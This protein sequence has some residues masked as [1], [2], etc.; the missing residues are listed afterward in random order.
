MQPYQLAITALVSFLITVSMPLNFESVAILSPSLTAV[1]TQAESRKAEAEQLFQQGFEQYQQGQ[2]ETA[3]EFWQQALKIYQELQIREKEGAV[4]GNLGIAYKILGEYAVAIDFHQQALAI[5]QQ[6][7]DRQGEGQVLGN[8]GNAYEAV[9]EYEKAIASYQQSFAIAQKLKDLPGEAI[10]LGNLGAI[11]ATLDDNDQA[12]KYYEQSLLIAQEIK[13][14]EIA[15]FLLNNL[16]TLYYTQNNVSKALATYQQSLEFAQAVGNQQ[17]ESE[18]LINLGTASE[19][20]GNHAQAIEHYNEVLKIAQENGDRRLEK[21]AFN[22]LG[23]ALFNSGN[24]VEAES[25]LREAIKIL[26]SLRPGLND[27]E[28]VSIFDTQILS[29][30][31]LQ[32]I[33]IAQDKFEA[34]LEVSE[35]GR[36]RAFVEL[37]AKRLSSEV[38]EQSRLNSDSPSIAKIKQIAQEHNATIVEYSLVPDEDF[39]VQGKQRGE[40]SE[41]LIWV[42]Q[43]T[44]KIAFRRV[45]L[46]TMRQQNETTL[47]SLVASSR[48]SMGVIGRGFVNLV[49]KP[50]NQQTEE[51]SLT[52]SLQKLHQLLIEPIT[53]FLPTDPNAR[54][55]F[56]PQESLFLVPF[57]ALQDA[58]GKYLIEK[59]TILTAPAIQ[60]LDLTYEQSQSVSELA[61]DILVVGNPTMPTFKNGDNLEQLPPLPG[62]EQEALMIASILNTKAL[63][64]DQATK[65]EVVQKLPKARLIHLAT[66][67]L[68]D[69]IKNLGIPGAIALAPSKND[70]GFLT[71]GEILNLKINAELVVLSA[72]D[73]G[74]GEITGDGVIGLSR[75]LIAAGTPSVIVSLWTVPD[76]PTALLMTEFYRY[77]Q[78]NSDKAQALRSAM[79]AT[80]KKYSLPYNWA[81]FT[82]IGE[83]E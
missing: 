78:E 37:L 53:E 51:V 56:I 16:G 32:Q 48:E 70:D 17:L 44:G 6:I 18:A 46:Q 4:L 20:L 82:L 2:L 59:H 61:Q 11:Y 66:H 69:D 81:A 39:K 30:N 80:K 57:P 13:N 25:K 27:T 24:L 26:E 65:V 34:A 5:M 49:P 3:V 76:Q 12:I 62:S 50:E 31:L 42:I 58:S 40:T 45:G 52:E 74:R 19:D 8:L 10:A 1:Q 77:L 41:I 7:K 21:S 43:P 54:A 64:G 23:H 14:P 63:I 75:S 28:K 36:A 60:V 47:A 67:G 33:L 9:G 38:A 73:T 15:G 68:L 29:Y 22:N 55:I 72:C 71:A 83:A 35:Q 79:L